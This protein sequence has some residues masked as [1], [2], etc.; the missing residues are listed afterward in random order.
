MP[1]QTDYKDLVQTGV[2]GLM[3]AIRQFDPARRVPFTSYARIRIRGTI[4]DSL[5]H[6][7][8]LLTKR[9]TDRRTSSDDPYREARLSQARRIIMDGINRLTEQERKVL[10]L[11]YFDDHEYTMEQVGKKLGVSESRISQILKT[12]LMHLKDE[13]ITR[14]A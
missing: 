12:G 14:W 2:L 8:W 11:Y 5:H 3:D 9:F 1:R 13:V 7:D 6:A 4:F 10:L